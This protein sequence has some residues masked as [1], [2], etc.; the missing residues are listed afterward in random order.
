MYTV[1]KDELVLVLREE[2]PLLITNPLFFLQTNKI[3]LNL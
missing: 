2:E 3:C 1:E